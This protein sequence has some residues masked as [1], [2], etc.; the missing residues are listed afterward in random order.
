MCVYSYVC[1]IPADQHDLYSPHTWICDRLF[2]ALMVYERLAPAWLRSRGLRFIASYIHA[3]DDQT[4]YVDIG[5]VNKVMNAL[6]VWHMS[7]ASGPATSHS[8]RSKEE[9]KVRVLVV[10]FTPACA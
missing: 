5:P 9:L 4:N 6:A 1:V 10:C 7:E 3:E 2:D 8:H